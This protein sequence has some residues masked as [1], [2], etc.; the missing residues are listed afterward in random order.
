MV[1]VGVLLY[2]VNMQVQ[3]RD[4]RLQSL[5]TRVSRAIETALRDEVTALELTPAQAETLRFAGT[6][7]PDVAT[8][9]QLARVLGVRHTTALGIL[10]PLTER[11]LIERQPHPFSARQHVL[12]LTDAGRT[13]L[14][15]LD[16]VESEIARAVSALTDD[17]AASLDRGLSGIARAFTEGGQLVVPAP[18]RGCIYFEMDAAFDADAPHYCR[19]IRRSLTDAGSRMLCPE[20]QPAG[21]ESRS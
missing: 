11:G 2:A 14:A 7:R 17:E 3:P 15:R 12:A 4:A 19:F 10:R 1:N 16:A 20:H 8:V 5:L 13:L 9:G 6:I 18:C 21:L